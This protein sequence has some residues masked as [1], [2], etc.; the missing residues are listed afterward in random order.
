METSMAWA[1]RVEAQRQHIENL[2]KIFDMGTKTDEEIFY[3]LCFCICAPQT[4]FK[5]NF[6]V[7]QVLQS[8]D[9]YNISGRILVAHDNFPVF[10]PRQKIEITQKIFDTICSDEYDGLSFLIRKGL[11]VGVPA[12]ERERDAAFLVEAEK[13]LS[14]LENMAEQKDREKFNE[15]LKHTHEMGTFQ[16]VKML[17]EITFSDPLPSSS[18]I[19]NN[20]TTEENDGRN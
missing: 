1:D 19:D 12:D 15:Y 14:M 17:N 6:A 5:S 13:M 11:I 10:K 18:Q 2:Y 4:T 20:P 7:N 16:K 3:D 9:F 8:R